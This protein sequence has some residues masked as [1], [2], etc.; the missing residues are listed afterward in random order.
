VYWTSY[1]TLSIGR[2][3]LDGSGVDPGFIPDVGY[4]L[5]VTVCDGHLYWGRG[6]DVIGRAALDGSAVDRA[7]VT[8]ISLPVAL[9]SPD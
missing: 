2:A 5:A 7:F 9:A 6:P 4:A 1:G 3:N 8:G